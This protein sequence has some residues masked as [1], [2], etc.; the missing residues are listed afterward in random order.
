LSE[1]PRRALVTLVK[2][3]L[4]FLFALFGFLV[5][6]SEKGSTS[7]KNTQ[8]FKI[9]FNRSSGCQMPKL[10]MG[11]FGRGPECGRAGA[12]VAEKGPDRGRER[13]GRRIKERNGRSGS[14]DDS[15]F[16]FNIRI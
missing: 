9:A 5:L 13:A 3:L 4:K 12:V 8:L 7:Q 14:G 2:N 16:R 1:T 10:S 15:M 11:L 6:F